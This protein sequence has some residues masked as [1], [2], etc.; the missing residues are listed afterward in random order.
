MFIDKKKETT[1]LD[2]RLTSKQKK[3]VEIMAKERNLSMSELVKTLLEIE[4]KFNIL[5]EYKDKI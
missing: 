2:V 5:N 1:R 4:M 3:L